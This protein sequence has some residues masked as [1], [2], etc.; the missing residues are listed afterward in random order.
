MN[1]SKKLKGLLAACVA[2]VGLTAFAAPKL[3]VG[4]VK[5]GEPWS[6]VTVNYTIGGTV[7][8]T[9]YKVAFDVTAGGQTASVTNDVV[10]L[11]NK[12]YSQELD[13][14]SAKLFGKQVADPQAKVKVSLI[15]IKPETLCG[16]QLW[17]GGP[18]FAEINVGATV[19]GDY[20]ELYT[21]NEAKNAAESLGAGWR[22]PTKAEWQGLLNNC[23][24]NWET[25][26][27]STGADIYGCRF[28]GATEGYTAKSIFLP[29]AGSRTTSTDRQSAGVF[30]RYW[31]DSKAEGTLLFNADSSG[32]TTCYNTSDF[33][34]VRAVR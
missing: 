24:S 4:E 20:G 5:T 10:N 21:F 25:C 2:A 32:L 27:D 8:V 34:S 3:T 28:T 29:A 15:V 11:E 14:A 30:G 13:T 18:F 6:K 7:A 1:I 19:P 22:R 33:S 26:K 12:Q 23:I 16:V 31:S 9:K 17:E